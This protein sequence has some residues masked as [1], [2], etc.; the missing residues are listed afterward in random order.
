M[1]SHDSG[2]T[3][4][5]LKDRLS[6]RLTEA[7]ELLDHPPAQQMDASGDAGPSEATKQVTLTSPC[8]SCALPRTADASAQTEQEDEAEEPEPSCGEGACGVTRKE[9]V[10]KNSSSITR[11]GKSTCTTEDGVTSTHPY[12]LDG[13]A[14]A[15]KTEESIMM[16]ED[17]QYSDSPSGLLGKEDPESVSMA[18]WRSRRLDVG[19]STL[20]DAIIEGWREASRELK[21]YKL[22]SPMNAKAPPPRADA[23]TMTE[24]FLESNGEQERENRPPCI[25]DGRFM[26]K[27][28]IDTIFGRVES[29]WDELSSHLTKDLRSRNNQFL[30]DCRHSLEDELSELQRD[31]RRQAKARRE[32]A[33]AQRELLAAMENE[34]Q[35]KY[36]EF[37]EWCDRYIDNEL[38]SLK[39]ALQQTE[40]YR[41]VATV[42]R[43]VIMN[44]IADLQE[45]LRD[46]AAVIWKALVELMERDLEALFKQFF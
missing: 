31:E 40:R 38:H 36:M 17:S 37:N 10:N 42:V 24:S 27:E 5:R 33:Q 44:S 28:E 45:I 7:P 12:Q 1:S 43:Y 41:G 18:S 11:A 22:H 3:R 23:S 19:P 14:E 16:K 39:L 25:H 13:T 2:A 20:E 34:F 4:E 6:Q 21:F 46:Q 29:R 8:S 32:M 35:V 15:S 26:V 30:A 9:E